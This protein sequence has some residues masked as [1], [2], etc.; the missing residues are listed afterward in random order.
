M[1]PP[2]ILNRGPYRLVP[3]LVPLPVV[4]EPVEPVVSL[5]KDPVVD[6][7]VLPVV[8]VPVKPV[9]DGLADPV[10]DAPAVIPVLSEP[11]TEETPVGFNCALFRGLDDV[12]DGE[13]IVP[14]VLVWA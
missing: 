12:S 3:V 11:P 4:D 1:I 13:P 9:V 8:D 14:P 6:D 5:P 10:V 7:P 2:E